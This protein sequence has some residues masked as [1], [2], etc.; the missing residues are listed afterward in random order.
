MLAFSATLSVPQ[1]AETPRYFD[2]DL[3]ISTPLLSG[4]PR[5]RF[6]TSLDFPPF[7]FA[8][9]NKKPTGMN[10]DLARAICAELEI[11][12]KCEIQALPWDDMEA[13]LNGQRG[14]AIIAGNAISGQMRAKYGLSY[15]YFRFPA[16]FLVRRDAADSSAT[17]MYE[18]LRDKRIA[19]I[20]GSAHA[21]MLKEYFPQA[22][23]LPL[24][25]AT[26][27]YDAVI[28]KEADYAFLD[29]VSASFWLTS[30]KAGNCCTFFGGPYYSTKYFGQGMAVVTRR[31]NAELRQAINAALKAIEE[32]GE[33][34]RIFER[35]FPNSPHGGG[36]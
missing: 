8:D 3:R 9:A 21:A 6:I 34:E 28:A 17:A 32:K 5:L 16:R 36:F 2:P 27:V 31:E 29:G 13:A 33:Y 30:E 20:E 1:A 11:E 19:V 12:S 22:I 35:Y 25:S 23:A 18:R 4:L 15:P 10:V 24:D 14:E 26:D 7:N